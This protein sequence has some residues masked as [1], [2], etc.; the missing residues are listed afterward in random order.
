[1]KTIV[2]PAKLEQPD[3]QWRIEWLHENA[4]QEEIFNYPEVSMTYLS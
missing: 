4:T 3:E 2:P 1:M